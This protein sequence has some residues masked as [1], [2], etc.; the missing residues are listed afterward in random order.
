MSKSGK[1]SCDPLTLAKGMAG[2]AVRDFD[3]DSQDVAQEETIEELNLPGHS[4][5]N[6][7]NFSPA[8]AKP[9]PRHK[10]VSI[11]GTD[12]QL[13]RLSM[14][15][16]SAISVGLHLVGP[17][18]LALLALL[19]LLI[20]SWLLHLNFWDFFKPKAP[21]DITYTLVDDTHVKRPEKPKF[22]GN[23]NQ[24]A[25]GKTHHQQPLNT[26]KDL[27][28][29]PK[30]QPPKPVTSAQPAKPTPAQQPKTEQQAQPKPK[31]PEEKTEK[32]PEP[33][34]PEPPKNITV[35]KPAPEKKPEQPKPETPKPQA[36][37]EAV[38]AQTAQPMQVT[39]R[40]TAPQP[41]AQTA[42]ESSVSNPQEGKAKDAGVDVAK[43]VDYGPFMAD[44]QK[45]ISRNW[46]PPRGMESRKMVLLFY[47]RHNGEVTRIDIKK[48]SGDRETDHSAIE[49]VQ[50]SAPFMPLPSQIQE[51]LLPV[52]FTFDYNVLNPRN[53]KH[54]LKW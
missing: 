26:D 33:A 10:G 15:Q 24:E 43:D 38:A 8:Q 5:E 23:V 42:A 2:S 47:V 44:L 54:A 36:P 11:V 14:T 52:E 51:D 29:R 6:P 50:V 13:A 45:R 53:A 39:T 4:S 16:A 32:Q 40:T 19:V 30:T 31:P 18:L 25:G 37:Q 21:Q 46:I 22:K 17:F 1:T 41:T 34:K 35:A 28:S 48:S 3:A 9:M 12:D 7:L 49:A 20:F 27:A